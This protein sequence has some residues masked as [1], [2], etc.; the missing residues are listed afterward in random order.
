MLTGFFIFSLCILISDAFNK[1]NLIID[2]D[3]DNENSVVHIKYKCTNTIYIPG[4]F[5][6]HKDAETILL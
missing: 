5:I 4:S 6:F 3:I 1:A 2:T